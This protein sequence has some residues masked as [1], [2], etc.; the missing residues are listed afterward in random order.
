MIGDQKGFSMAFLLAVVSLLSCC[1][2]SYFILPR[3]SRTDDAIIIDLDGSGYA[4]PF[5]GK[6]WYGQIA[7]PG[8]IPVPS[9]NPY[10]MMFRQQQQP[11]GWPYPSGYLSRLEEEP[12]DVKQVA[13]TCGGGPATMPK[14]GGLASGRVYGA[15]VAKKGAW[16]FIVALQKS[17]DGKLF[18]S[19]TLISDTK[20]LLA[21]QCLEALSL[22]EIS[23]VT[24]LIGMYLS[25]QSD[26]QMTRRITKVVLHDKYNAFNY[27]NDIAILTLDA[28]VAI[29]KTVGPACLPPASSDPDQYVEENAIIMGWGTEDSGVIKLQQTKT[30]IPIMANTECKGDS[31][32]GK[33][34]TDATICLDTSSTGP[35]ACKIDKGGPVV[36]LPSPGAWTVVGINSYTK[37]C[38]SNG[39]KT[40]VSAYRTWIDTYMK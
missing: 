24:A 35:Y 23:S 16:P 4:S 10:P 14:T 19:G 37:D 39:L 38:F 9:F 11:S 33:Y 26:V 32:F 27:A 15:I 12:I 30:A 18:C 36:I 28:P 34:V 31:T 20:V 1:Q 8:F 22:Y 6:N 2:A 17:T 5:Q 3:V 25:D 40:R 7:N 29:S 21:A 13:A